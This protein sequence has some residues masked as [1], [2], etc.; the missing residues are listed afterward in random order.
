MS[1][2]NETAG[3]RQAAVYRLYGAD[4]TL[5]YIGSTFDPEKRFQ[6]HRPKP[7]WP[8]V[9]RH[10]VEWHPSKDDA[11]AAEM[12][13]IAAEGPAHNHMGTPQYVPPSEKAAARRSHIGGE[14]TVKEIMAKYKISRQSL[15]TYRQDPTFPLPA[16]RP[17]TGGLRWREDEVAAW[18]AANPKQQGKKRDQFISR[19]QGETVMS[20]YTVTLRVEADSE[21]T[22]EQIRQEIYD[23]CP[24]VPFGFDIT[25]IEPEG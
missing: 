16:S 17:G 7:W 24:D 8:L 14:L 15:H 10:T 12:A 9:T 22:P 6:A 19:Q 25:S 3:Q 5:L 1:V 11:Y 4:D 2:Q 23:A 20:V 18:F 21:V 13:A